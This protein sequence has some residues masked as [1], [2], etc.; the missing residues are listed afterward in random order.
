MPSF[1]PLSSGGLDAGQG[2]TQCQATVAG[3]AE[4]Q[5]KAGLKVGTGIISQAQR[6]SASPPLGP[7]HPVI[8]LAFW[9]GLPLGDSASLVWL[10]ILPNKAG[11][12]LLGGEGETIWPC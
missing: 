6:P 12:L 10:L 7:S 9:E 4:Q 8:F 5:T 1:S 3:W 11:F 2:Q